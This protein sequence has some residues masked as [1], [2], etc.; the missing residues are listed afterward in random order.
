MSQTIEHPS[1]A[2]KE[3][4]MGQEL[5]DLQS[6]LGG[7]Y[8]K[9]YLFSIAA[10]GVGLFMGGVVTLGIFAGVFAAVGTGL[11]MD[12]LKETFPEAYNWIID[13]PGWM[14][15]IT[16]IGFAGAFGLTATGIVGGL[17]ANILS[18]VVI[19]Y[20]TYKEGKVPGVHT[21][22]IGSILLKV[23]NWFVG[24]FSEVKTGIK[25]LKNSEPVKQVLPDINTNAVVI[26]NAAA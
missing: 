9:K 24:L 12:R 2:T 15:I 6:M 1:D 3:D 22:T 5:F 20:Y 14:E 7:Q 25:Q 26:E 8:M 23:K 11:S 18:S 19:D 21:L 17:I 4:T 16:T 10:I 13:H